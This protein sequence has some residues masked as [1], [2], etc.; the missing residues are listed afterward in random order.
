MEDKN[1]GDVR[2][3]PE[4]SIYK[5]NEE[6]ISFK[7]GDYGYNDLY[8]ICIEEIKSNDSNDS[9]VNSNN[10]TVKANG[11]LN[12]RSGAGKDFSKV[13]LI[14]DG[15]TVEVV[16]ESGEWSLVKYNSYTGWVKSS[17]LR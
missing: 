7:P 12:M 14:P 16:E 11:G 17:Y 6:Y 13:T 8:D 15:S 3:Y 1:T 4:N 10:A 2:T 9:P 5:Y